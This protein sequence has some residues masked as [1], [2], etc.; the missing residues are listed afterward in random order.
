VQVGELKSFILRALGSSKKPLLGIRKFLNDL[1][2][3]LK[4]HPEE[5]REKIKGFGVCGL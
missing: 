2:K 5:A 1:K 4:A 3:S